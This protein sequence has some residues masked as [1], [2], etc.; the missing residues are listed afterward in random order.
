MQ[1]DFGMPFLLET[2]TIADA[3]ALCAELGLSFVELN[4][5]FPA[6]Q[7]DVLDVQELYELKR[8]YGIY[9]TIHLEE[10]CNPLCFNRCVRKAWLDSIRDTLTI[11][12][13]IDAPIV[14][15]HL[16][17]GDYITLP[18]R[19]VHMFAYYKDD[20]QAAVEE[21]QDMCR[22]EL[23]GSSTRICIEN[24]NG[25]TPYEQRAIS[26]LFESKVFGLTLDIGHS[27]AAGDCD[28]PF[29]RAF[30]R[31]MIHMHV[32]DAKGSSNHLALGDG[33][34]D[35]KERFTWARRNGARI[36]LETKT[37]QALRTSVERL[38]RIM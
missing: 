25:F 7:A 8:R 2:P 24:T 18:D 36:V 9:F 37:I 29:Y 10:G 28:I 4:M 16:P 14:N 33:E 27:H 20:Y 34:I 30:D 38:H 21:L 35:L 1:N 23:E 5:N 31:K 26:M 11:A 3:A 32:H 22:R 6:C 17:K 12:Q 13:A 15:M 19:K